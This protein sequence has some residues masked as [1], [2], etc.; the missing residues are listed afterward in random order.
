MNILNS[1]PASNPV[2]VHRRNQNVDLLL[3]CALLGGI[4][5]IPAKDTNAPPTARHDVADTYFGTSV[6]DPYR[7]LENAQDKKVHD[8]SA[9]QD[10][11]TR[12]YLDGLPQRKAIF[13]QLMK[14]T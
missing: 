3:L 2:C 12:K 1:K 4:L 6:S 9:A 14:Q 10:K 8:W 7:W 5:S 11:R 13:N